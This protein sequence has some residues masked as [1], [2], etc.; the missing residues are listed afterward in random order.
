MRTVR[1]KSREVSGH[2]K[3]KFRFPKALS[4]HWFRQS[5]WLDCPGPARVAAIFVTDFADVTHRRIAADIE[6]K[7]D[8]VGRSPVQSL[9]CRR[10]RLHSGGA[11]V[12]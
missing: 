6:D 3:K 4:L 5:A 8:A 12:V 9:P 10:M 2:L 7:L 11:L 1:E